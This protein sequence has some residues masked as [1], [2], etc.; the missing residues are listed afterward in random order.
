MQ[1]P[2][3][4]AKPRLGLAR[5]SLLGGALLFGGMVYYVQSQDGA[6][7]TPTADVVRQLRYVGYGVWIVAV[8][9]ILFV[10]IRLGE[11]IERGSPNLSLIGWALAEATALFGGVYYFAT[12]DYSLWV[13]GILVMV[14]SFG[15]FPVPRGR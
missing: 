10:K 6:K 9:G 2:T 11:T 14:V 15:L 7:P 1:T 3:T 12:G 4:D 13:A 8:A 5:I